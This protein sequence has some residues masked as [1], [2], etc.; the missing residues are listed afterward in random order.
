M[1]N[2]KGGSVADFAGSMAEEMEKAMEAEM[3]ALKGHGL[4][5]Q[6]REERRLLLAAVARGMLNYLKKH[7]DEILR[8]L[9]FDAGD[10]YGDLGGPVSALELG[11][12]VA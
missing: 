1:A 6:G 12:E 10:G 3:R 11:T 5:E 8:S 2:L 4:P 7:E 9:A